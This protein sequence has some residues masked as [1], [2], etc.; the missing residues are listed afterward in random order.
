MAAK[1][2]ILVVDD[3]SNARNALAELLKEEGYSVETAADG[4]KG[5]SRFHEFGPDL[6]LTDL[7]MPGMD[8][9]ELLGKVRE[10]DPD[11]SVIVTTAFG[12]VE[13]A[14]TAM[15]AG[16]LDYLT[17]PINIDELLIVL[18]RALEQS[19]LRR[20]AHALR[21]QLAERYRFDNVIGSSPKMQQ[22]FKT[23]AQVAP[24]RATIL[25]TG[26]SG[27]GKELIAA[28]IHH[29]SP[30]AGGPFVKLHCAALAESLLESE[31][32]GHER[33]AF[34]GAD[35]R[36][37]GRFEQ[38]DGG[39]LFLD[40]I[41]EISASTQVKLLRVLQEHEFER[42]G[43]NQTVRVD[44]RVIAATNR[45]L[46]QQVAEGKFREDLFYRLNVINIHLPS[47]RER[48]SDV[49]ALAT[50]F[51]EHYA[52]ENQKPIT[53]FSDAALSRLVGYDWPGN[54]RELENVVERAVVLAEGAQ[55]EPAHLPPEVEPTI[56]TRAAPL[57]PGAN[58]ADIERFAILST[59]EAQGGSTSRAA[60]VLGIS[61]RKIQ[62]KLQEYGRA[63]KSGV[64][65]VGAK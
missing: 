25:L 56:E 47:L 59:L 26:E 53:R 65:A 33:G 61:V 39:T 5:L 8:G 51:L 29:R 24:S 57:I 6:V 42:V 15:R 16:A 21:S 64:P 3:E 18:E 9:I 31:L 62:Y 45:E 32:F 23:V 14:V 43:G 22:V 48:T 7:K 10:A 37:E 41:G 44:V 46:K 17:K 50:H 49:P 60:D 58:M 40:E 12:A 30:R 20:E 35:R 1:G 19:R 11:V 13:T 28:A 34:T 63:P 55:I 38:A 52:R 4:F 27:T 36:R 2:R 54:V